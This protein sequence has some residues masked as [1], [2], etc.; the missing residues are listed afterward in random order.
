MNAGAR[1]AS[2]DILLFLHAD[3]RLPEGAD[4][5]VSDALS[6]P[7]SVWGRF[8]VRIDGRSRW[9]PVIA[10]LM[11]F[12]SRRSGIATGDQAIFVRRDVFE[13]MGGFPG[14]ALM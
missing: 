4:A 8:D 2:G 9:F 7:G 3:T 12:R 5:L 6:L 11:N 13:A 1:S 14:I 10:A